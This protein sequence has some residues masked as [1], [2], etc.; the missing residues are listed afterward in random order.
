MSIINLKINQFINYTDFVPDN[1]VYPTVSL[2]HQCHQH[3]PAYTYVKDNQ[4][5]MVKKCRVHGESHHMIERDYS[6]IK[7]LTY[8]INKYQMT[9]AILMEVT[10]RCN[11]DCPHCYHEPESKSID[12]PIET[13]LKEIEMFYRRDLKLVLTGAE[14]S[15]RRDFPELIKTI[16]ETYDIENLGTMTNGIRFSDYDYLKECVDNGLD[17]VSI[18]LNHPSYIN[19]ETIRNKQIQGIIN[20]RELCQHLSYV[21]YTMSSINELEDI[22][23]EATTSDWNPGQFRI[24]YGSD[25]GR[26]PE[27]ERMYVTDIFKYTEDWCARNGKSFNIVEDADNNIYHVMVNIDGQDFRLIQWCDETDINLEELMNGP[28]CNFVDDGVTNFLHQ[29]IRRDISKNKGIAL[30]DT[31]PK[32]YQIDY[33]YTQPLD[34]EKLYE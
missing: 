15:V 34:F 22:L 1:M 24:R 21:G 4:L 5:W 18:G 17:G 32:R 12:K 13:V 16:R 3:I 11:I 10:D 27:Q 31:P 30:L 33:D 23:L 14:A 9:S 28:W 20:S 29:I 7:N 8:N 2:C 6:L 25:I 19:N 26:Y